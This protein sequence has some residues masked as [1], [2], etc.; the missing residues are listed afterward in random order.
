M[1]Y[2]IESTKSVNWI[3]IRIYTLKDFSGNIVIS[4]SGLSYKAVG[5]KYNKL[6]FEIAKLC[7]IL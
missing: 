7:N 3:D 6:L 1:K 5:K 4:F 2:K